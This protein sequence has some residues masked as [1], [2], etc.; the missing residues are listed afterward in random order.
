MKRL[1][2]SA[3]LCLFSYLALSQET[4]I[5]GKVSDLETNEPIP[6]A[7]V[8]FKGTKIGVNTD[9]EGKYSI[10]TSVP[11]DSLTVSYIGYKTYSKKI[12]KGESQ[13]LN[14]NM[15]PDGFVSQEIVIT[16]GE[17]PAYP[18]MRKV[19]KNKSANN[20][21]GLSAFEY[22]AYS[23]TEIDIDNISKKMRGKK[24]MRKIM[25][26]L[27]SLKKVTDDDGKPILP[28]FISET[29]SKYYYRDSPK[30]SKED[31]IA[32]KI[33]GIA[34]DD[35]GLV[36]Q[37]VGST[38]QQYNFYDSWVNFL[39]KDFVS[40]L[41]D[42]WKLYYEYY[43]A[44]S[45]YIDDDFCYQIEI[46][47][48]RPQDLA[49]NGVIWINKS[50]FA[51]KRID[52]TMG[53]EA[54]LNFIE[55][56]KIQQ[57]LSKTDAGPYLP[58]KSRI[59]IDIAEI[60][61]SSAGM[62]LK[63][64]S[65]NKNY[66]VNQ[67]QPLKFFDQTV[68]VA[69][70]A[71]M[72]SEEYWVENRH[73]PLSD[74]EKQMFVMIDSIKNIPV[75]K[76]YVDIFDILLNGYKR[77]GKFDLGPYLFTYAINN[78]EGS[79]FRL[80]GRTNYLFSKKLTFNAYGAY[81][82]AD[83]KFKY[84]AGV[85]Y[86]LGKNPWRQMGFD[87]SYDINQVGL[88]SFTGNP[89][90]LFAAS[91]RWGTLRRQFMQTEAKLYFE[92]PIVKDLTETV[93]FRYLK[94]DPLY[95]FS[96]LQDLNS[97]LRNNYFEVNE[98]SFSTRYAKDERFLRNE[99]TRISMGTRK[100]P[101][102]TFK[103]TLGFKNVMGGMYDYQKYLFTVDH[104][105]R[106]GIFGRLDYVIQAGYIPTTLPYPL[107]ENHLGNETFFFNVQAFNLMNFSEF[108]S[109]RFLSISFRHYFEGFI[110]NKIPLFS[111]L[112]LREV[113]TLKLLFGTVSDENIALN[114]QDIGTS[115]IAFRKL[116]WYEPY[117]EVGYGIENIFKFARVD[118]L[119]RLT[120]LN[121]QSQYFGI[122]LSAH[123]KL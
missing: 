39:R 77:I 30:T 93:A 120:Y 88:M 66:K 12:K 75:V 4:T 116:N 65:S 11:L 17:N 119:H 23:K 56:M 29:M 98:L 51:L 82:T 32:N 118:F 103:F 69:E 110:F 40:P 106:I 109:D 76:T 87:Y 84:G 113:A 14:F 10:I 112:K 94:F 34:L 100:W 101:V 67:A 85:S 20:R 41:A 59:I 2:F 45:V 46:T 50:D 28:V 105:A 96:Y 89:N 36:S 108:A 107:L 123:F 27:D 1:Y 37:L 104:Y 61:D 16:S 55:K 22:D 63:F 70:D 42:S 54:N 86:I 38:F 111:K 83:N 121:P 15:K 114:K 60:A 52:V 26:A 6:F 35:G 62:I 47:P 31:V 97:T 24:M 74:N 91:T 73:D 99:N 81:G 43:L 102:L 90:G 3:L 78:E 44:D 33:S 64:Y 95:S 122:R 92:T 25:R 71:K 13:S 80:G 19:M 57:T 115:Q 7:N 9:F 68:N 72:K 117:V 21:S 18:I 8:F 53:K 58:S 49:F 79:R 48:R 5:K